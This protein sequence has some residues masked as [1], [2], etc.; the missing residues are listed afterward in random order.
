[1]HFIRAME[2]E[3]YRTESGLD[4]FD[5]DH[6]N[7]HH[8]FV[9]TICHNVGTHMIDC[10]MRGVKESVFYICIKGE[11][12]LN[13][14]SDAHGYS[15]SLTVSGQDLDGEQTER[16]G[17]ALKDAAIL[18]AALLE[19]NAAALR[20]RDALKAHYDAERQLFAQRRQQTRLSESERIGYDA[21]KKFFAQKANFV[22]EESR[23]RSN[24]FCDS[25]GFTV[26]DCAS[27]ATRRCVIYGNN[28]RVTCAYGRQ[29][30]SA[31]MLI[32]RIAG[33]DAGYGCCINE[34]GG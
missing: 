19:D 13:D 34:S 5:F 32:K 25:Y 18:I 33:S 4:F 9:E 16:L 31:A 7:H 21:A 6:V 1:M 3:T 29:S 24:A 20:A 2:R 17:L 28:G 22:R 23:K 12:K 11:P 26:R 10:Y 27:G 8:R 30:I 15:T 14:A